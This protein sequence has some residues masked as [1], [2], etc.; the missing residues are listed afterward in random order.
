MNFISSMYDTNKCYVRMHG[1]D[2]PGFILEGGVR[3]GCPLSPLLFAVCVDIL[4]RMIIR[5]APECTCKAFAD[6]IAALLTDWWKQGP[7]LERVFQEFE[8]I[9]NLGLNI[10][11]TVCIPLWIDGVGEARAR[12]PQLILRWADVCVDDKGVYLGFT[13]GPG[14]GT[15]SWDKPLKKFKDRVARWSGVGGGL[16]QAALA[17][18]VFALSTLLYIA[19]LE[20]IPDFVIQEERKLVLSMFPGPG[21]W[22]TPEDLWFLREGLGLAKCP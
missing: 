8:Q 14:K 7:L 3:Q 16:Q 18:N 20:P 17:Y 2:F 15:G 1:H 6:D 12:T 13:V 9:S 21:N 11:K 4:L 19:Q 5:V 22:I 10:S